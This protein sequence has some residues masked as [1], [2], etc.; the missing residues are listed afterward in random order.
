MAINISQA[1]HRTSANPIDDTLALTKAEML[2]VND[3]LMPSKYLTVCQ[4]DGQIYLYDKNATP[5]T[6][7]GKFILFEA[8]GGGSAPIGTVIAFMG[9]TAP[10]NYVACDGTI[11]NISDYP[12]LANFFE[13]QFGTKNNFGGDGT[14]T[15]AVPNLNGEFLR[16]T[17]TN[18][19]TNQGSGA[20]VG[21]HQDATGI[22]FGIHSLSGSNGTITEYWNEDFADSVN[23]NVLPQNTDGDI[24]GTNKSKLLRFNA[25]E[26]LASAGNMQFKN[27]RPTAT[28]VL[29][30]ICARTEETEQAGH[31]YST[32]EH[33]VGTWTNGKNIYEKLIPINQ[34][35]SAG[36]TYEVSLPDCEEIIQHKFKMSWSDLSTDIVRIVDDSWAYQNASPS[37]ILTTDV[38]YRP[39]THKI[40]FRTSNAIGLFYVIAQYTK[41]TD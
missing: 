20:N 9:T 29:F 32:T 31:E 11:Y 7:T 33:I 27:V 16:G 41:T 24:I 19:H 22:L 4:D 36:E 6:E 13:Q 26:V 17:G 30:C 18:G 2:T 8:G 37:N 3:N 35:L 21:V 14:T 23:H 40:I 34:N 12:K 1:F 5:S 15:F 10:T 28:S 38:F 39:S 25:D